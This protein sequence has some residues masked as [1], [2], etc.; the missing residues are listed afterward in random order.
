MS[1]YK[2]GIVL[3]KIYIVYVYHVFVANRSTGVQM[4]IFIGENDCYFVLQE[5]R[6]FMS[7]NICM[8]K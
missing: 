2:Q 6:A 3:V 1:L 5:I 7:E 4:G 8:K